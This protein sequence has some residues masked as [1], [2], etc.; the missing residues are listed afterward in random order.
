MSLMRRIAEQ[1]L[2][3][4]EAEHLVNQLAEEHVALAQA[5]RRVLFGQQLAD[6]RPDLALG[7]RP[8]GIAP[9]PRDSGG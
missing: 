3:R 1:R 8:V 7:A 2:Q 5:E 9:A 6:E 4:P